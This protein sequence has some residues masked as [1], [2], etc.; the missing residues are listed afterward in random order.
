LR[1]NGL[2]LRNFNANVPPPYVPP[3]PIAGTLITTYC[4]G[5]DKYGTYADGI[6]GTYNQLI[7]ANSVFCGYIPAMWPGMPNNILGFTASTA[8][9]DAKGYLSEVAQ[10]IDTAII[11]YNGSLPTL[12]KKFKR[13]RYDSIDLTPY[14]TVPVGYDMIVITSA[15]NY[16]LGLIDYKATSSTVLINNPVFPEYPSMDYRLD[17]VPLGLYIR[18]IAT[19]SYLI[20][21]EGTILNH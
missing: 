18:D 5:V 2:F 13:N 12:L 16:H 8:Y 6:G 17:W 10:D 14:Q 21:A 20:P 1:G 3:H 15:H 9:L 11:L 4:N 7:E 19:W